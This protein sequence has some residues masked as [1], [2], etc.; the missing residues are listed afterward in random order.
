[1]GT[2]GSPGRRK[3]ACSEC[4]CLPSS[5]VRPAATSAWPA[6]WPPNTRWRSSSGL[7]PR[8]ML[9]SMASRS[10]SSTRASRALLTA[11]HPDF[12]ASRADNPRLT[13]ES[14]KE[15]PSLERRQPVGCR[16]A[17]QLGEL[18]N[19]LLECLRPVEQVIGDGGEREPLA[20][21]VLVGVGH[22]QG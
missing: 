1:M 21:R 15:R 2:V 3:Y 17:A 22:G 16:L 14:Q 12:R 10:S 8:K 13:H 18:A 20:R 6:T 11:A 9:T 19:A 7:S 4:T 5:T